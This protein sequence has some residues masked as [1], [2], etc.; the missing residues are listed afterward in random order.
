M[1]LNQLKLSKSEWESIE[2][3]VSES[4]IKILKLITNGYSD[5]N[6]KYNETNSLF[7]FLKIEYSPQ[8]EEFLYIKHFADKIK[9]LVNKYN[10]TFIRFS[11]DS[12]KINRN[13]NTEA[14]EIGQ[15]KICYIKLCSIVKLKSTEQIRLGRSELINEETTEIY[16][17]VLY[18]QLEKLLHF[19]SLN[20]VIWLMYYY[21]LSKLMGNNIDKVN[22]FLKKV[23]TAVLDNFED[24]V[25]LQSIIRNSYEYIEK[26]NNLL[27]YG[28]LQLYEHQKTVFT[29]VKNVNP[30]LILYIAP[31]G[32]GKTLTPL[33]L[34]EGNKII[35]VCAARHVGIALARAAVSISKK[36]AFAF[37]CSSAS[38]IRLHYFAAKEYTRD[39]RSGR[40][41]KVDNSVGD[42]VE[43]IICDIRS[44]LP[45]MYYMTAFNKP[46]E[47]ITYWDEP[48][49]TMDYDN[50]DLH[51]IIKRNWK[52]NIIPNVVLSSA[53]LPKLHEL[54]QTISDFTTKFSNY[55]YIT[56]TD[57]N[58]IT[59]VIK[60]PQI[61]NIVSHDCRKTIPILNNNGYI[62]MPHYLS[63]NYTELM[64]IVEQCEDNLTLLRYFDLQESSRFILFVEEN[65][66]IKSAAKFNRNFAN[67][68]DISMQS[69]K[70]H[71]LKTLKNVKPSD[72]VAIYLYFNSNRRQKIQPN[73]TI[74]PKG[75]KITH[76][77]S[78]GPGVTGAGPKPG[79]ELTRTISQPVHNHIPI[80][81]QL[82]VAQQNGSS[83]IYVTTKDAYT[84]TDGP[85][86]F[87]ATDVTKVAKFCIQQANIPASVMK[88]IQDKIDY[89]NVINGKINTLELDLED[90]QEKMVSKG[91]SGGAG[92]DKKES[93]KKEKIACEKMDKTTDK[94]VVK[95]NSQLT[96]LR[97][98][99]KNATLNDLFVPNKL[100]H[101]N[102]WADGISSSNSF[103]SNVDEDDILSI[104][105]LN[106]VDDSW[107]IL[108]LLGIGVFTEH[109]S[110][111]YTEIMKRLA[112]T[113]KLYLIIADSDYIYGTNYQFCHG[114]LSK[115]LLLTQEKIIQALGRIGRN[116][117]QQEY[118]ARFRDDSHIKLLFEKI[119]SNRKP[120]VINMNILFNSKKVVWDGNDFIEVQDEPEKDDE[121]IVVNEDE[122][123]VSDDDKDDIEST[124]IADDENN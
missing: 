11:N 50:H 97:Q 91:A 106:D 35:F 64:T 32:T 92:S 115:D 99:I 90:I 4:E 58:T 85:T 8:L 87:L 113:Q 101:K 1:N 12:S 57:N 56:I 54:T 76:S 98:M 3:P 70:L 5:V 34:S 46:E 82:N 48:T 71:Y 104:M 28:D 42:K 122:Y 103:T 60:Q 78:I 30:K 81:V 29:A 17:F 111:A 23:I 55:K 43:I 21:T 40:I 36:V 116:N 120:E 9:L 10:L 107:K 63:E 65:E 25:D 20:N 6:I 13:E 89:N 67:I 66:Y 44:Y 53:T 45:A 114:Y 18:K 79:A 51:R 22:C 93:K 96:L 52:N 108:L 123:E 7:S 119:D 75:Q 31:T 68:H 109:K 100:A 121:N 37:G 88:E 2:I 95:L 72:W 59:S 19:K 41:R 74:D 102:K 16:E 62:V 73:N 14:N 80:P 94:E 38:D 47:I 24:E 49:I 26:N 61:Y 112:D 105:M 117:I 83:A 124:E 86:I 15:T 27:K 84:L 77:S 118:S 39:K 33:G 110:S 69:I